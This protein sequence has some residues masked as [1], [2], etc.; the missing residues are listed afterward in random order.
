MSS[1][2]DTDAHPCWMPRHKSVM[3]GPRM[4]T[5]ERAAA[6]ALAQVE[7]RKFSSLKPKAVINSG[8]IGSALLS[9][10]MADLEGLRLERVRTE[11]DW[12]RFGLLKFLDRMDFHRI[13]R[14]LSRR[15]RVA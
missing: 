5:E 8:G 6:E 1:Q 2:R 3:T 11:V 12:S 15:G 9:Q 14:H 13:A 7:F 4:V 10:V